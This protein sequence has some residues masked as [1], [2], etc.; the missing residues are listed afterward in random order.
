[1]KVALCLS[2]TL[3]GI[4]GKS[5]EKTGGADRILHL[6]YPHF[7]KHILDINDVDVFVHSW[8]THLAD[9]IAN[10]FRPKAHMFEEQKIFDIPEHLDNTQRV[11][12]H[13]SRW[14][15]VNKVVHLQKSYSEAYK[16]DYD[17]VMVSR[18]DLA[19]TTDVNFSDLDL[20]YFYVANWYQHH[21]SEPMGYPHGQ[22]NRSL[23]D[24]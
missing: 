11:Q 24:C 10:V 4:K 19:W 21:T 6:A 7:K 14:Y 20:N 17:M 8:D 1:M 18:M 15:G 13:F 12:N 2:G 9:D 22:Y 3:G 5:G 16:V 23:Q